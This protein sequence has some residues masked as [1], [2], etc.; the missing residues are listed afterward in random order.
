MKR[1]SSL[2]AKIELLRERLKSSRQSA[3][4]LEP[5]IAAV[6]VDLQSSLDDLAATAR[7]EMAARDE[8]AA[9][10]SQL[11]EEEDEEE[12]ERYRDLF[13]LAPEA[14]F[15]TNALGMIRAA[16]TAAAD[17]LGVER[18]FL[19]GKPL[20]AFVPEPERADFRTRLNA[21]P[22]AR[23]SEWE[24]SLSPRGHTPV[25]VTFRVTSSVGPT[26]H[27]G[28]LRWLVR[29]VSERNR[30]EDDVRRTNV[31]LEARVRERTAE[32][33]RANEMKTQLLA[34]EREARDFAERLLA[35]ARETDRQK[36]EYIAMLA[37]ELRNP[38]AP[39][40]NA[41][42]TIETC[43]EA[44]PTIDRSREIAERQVRH[45][46]RM[47]DDLLD[48]SRVQRGLVSLDNRPID[49][50][51]AVAR[52]A[53]AERTAANE[54]EHQLTID[55]S[56]EPLW[57]QGDPTRV[58]QI[59]VNLLN[60]AI[61]YT[62]AGGRI[63]LRVTREGAEVVARVRDDG[64]GISHE[65]LP[66]VFEP[67]TQAQQ[68]LARSQGGLG[69]GLALVHRLVAMHGGS[70]RAT[71]EGEDRGTEFIV[72]FPLTAAPAEEAAEAVLDDVP[73]DFD[74]AL[75][76]LI[77]DDNHD[78]AN[79]LAEILQ[80]W[81]YDTSVAYDGPSALEQARRRHPEAVLLDIG[82]PGMDGFEVSR[83]M[84]E[85]SGMERSLVVAV[86]GYGRDRDREAAKDAGFDQHLTKPVDPQAIHRLLS[87]QSHVAASNGR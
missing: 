27:R 26:G 86:S 48:L 68:T 1:H 35:K 32:L 74:K 45:L 36:D 18:G 59:F 75:R 72:R 77:V 5:G 44:T 25:E 73:D 6:L 39:I 83:R 56:P 30:R 69:L 51:H 24:G 34:R 29:D 12:E 80:L 11:E 67:F 22:L 87:E 7:V 65:L 60:N 19:A 52:A 40:V 10:R 16:N 63:A 31:A 84:R 79:S 21:L 64:V 81:G 62:P 9:T 28:R 42:R 53:D 58:E 46:V 85:I 50:G 13:D 76:V 14:Y 4:A 17:M 33:E 41:L 55:L 71:S 47:V 23:F 38:L 15:V 82:L 2:I 78:A 43:G 66:H 3:V 49:L 61:K 57:I 37:H 20:A 8:T 54:R 70:V